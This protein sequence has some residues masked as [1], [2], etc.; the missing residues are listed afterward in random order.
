[1]TNRTKATA[2]AKAKGRKGSAARP[3]TRAPA[4]RSSSSTWIAIGAVLG[5]IVL[6][7][8][9]FSGGGEDGGDGFAPSAEGT[10]A[11]DRQAGPMLAP[12]EPVPGFSAP[13]LDSGTFRWSDHVGEPTVLSV[14]APWCPH[15]QAELPRL[16]AAAEAHPDVRLVTV[17]TAYGVQP[18][19][20]PPEYLAAEG[21]SFPVAVDDG[22]QTLMRG[23]GVQSF[24][25]TYFVGS[26]GAVVRATTGEL[27]PADL[28]AYLTELEGR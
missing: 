22:A 24:P 10:V 15:C 21:L 13:A 14:W 4:G 1:M 26:D 5:V 28:E 20:T 25:T 18:G 12:G 19:P 2:K 23:L 27:E 16:A 9:F 17:T 3:A 6:A 8:M 7:V 11:I